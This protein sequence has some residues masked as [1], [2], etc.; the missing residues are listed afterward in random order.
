MQLKAQAKLIADPDGGSKG[1]GLQPC[2]SRDQQEGAGQS[3]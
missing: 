2:A 3:R 1:A